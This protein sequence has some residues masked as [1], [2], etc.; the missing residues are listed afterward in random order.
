MRVSSFDFERD[1]VDLSA[2]D[3]ECS[4]LNRPLANTNDD[5]QRVR[6]GG[7]RHV[8]RGRNGGAVRVGM[9][10]PED[11]LVTASRLAPGLDVVVRVE[12]KA[13]RARFEISTADRLRNARADAKQHTATLARRRF[14][15]VG[16][17]LVTRR[18]RHLHS[19]ST[20]M[21]MP[22]PPP[23]HSAATP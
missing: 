22:I 5:R 13:R 12:E 19:D 11:L 3:S 7:L 8:G 1:L 21:A 15:R 2:N 9:I 4:H 18:A 23:M 16:E 6:I 17:N 10:E 14:A 20:T